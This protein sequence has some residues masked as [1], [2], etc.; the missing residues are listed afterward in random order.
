MKATINKNIDLVQIN[1]AAGTD[2]YYLPKNVDWNGRTIDR[3][4]LAAPTASVVS[5]IDGTTHVLTRSEIKDLYFDLYDGNDAELTH[6]LSFEQILHTNNNPWLPKK[7]L[8][9]NLSRM[10]F[11]T[12]PQT[13]GCILL[14]VFYGSQEVEDIEFPRKS[15]TVEVNLAADEQKSFQEIINTSIHAIDQRVRGIMV[16]DADTAP[17]YLTLRDHQLSY[18]LNS[19]YSGLLRPIMRKNNAEATQIHAALFDAIDIDFD[20]SFIRNA[21][22]VATKQIIT[23]EY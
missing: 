19:V 6:G 3:I 14:Y 7:Q 20:Y 22:S 9:L 21:G 2:E 1:I 17:V 5:P 4:V 15:I 18:I 13:S 23:F 16:W 8:S 12:T 11:T 10:Y